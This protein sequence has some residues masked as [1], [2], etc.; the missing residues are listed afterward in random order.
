MNARAVALALTC[1]FVFSTPCAP[2][3]APVTKPV[4][5]S[6]TALDIIELEIS[7]TTLLA[8]YYK[9][10]KP[11]LL[12]DGARN[13]VAAELRAR[14]IENANL[15]LTP[16]VVDRPTGSDLID[17]LVLHS[18]ARYGSKLDGHALVNAAVEGELGILRDPY[19]VLFRP[20]AFEKFSAFLGNARF[21]GIGAI[22]SLD[23]KTGRAPIERA[24]PDS[25]AAKAGLSGGDAIVA[26]DGKPVSELSGAQ[27][28]LAALRGKIGTPVALDIAKADG[29]TVHLAL[30]RAALRDP[31]I[32]TKQF[33]N[34]SYIRL[35]RFGDRAGDEVETAARDAY[36]S[37]RAVVLDLRGNGGGYGDEATKVASV[38]IPPGP[39]F[40]TRERI[41]V[42][43]VSNTTSIALPPHGSLAVLVDGDTASAAE[44]VAGAVQDDGAGIVVGTKTFGKG[45]VQ[46]IFALPDGSAI[47]MT[48]A[49]YTTP[50]GRDIDGVGIVPDLIVAEPAGSVRGDPQTDPQLAAALS[51]L[52]PFLA[53]PSPYAP[54]SHSP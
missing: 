6:L 11:R 22:V 38:F 20:Q 29:T 19:T 37:G 36:R 13:G 18:L 5:S 17:G 27:A 9:D 48:T 1:A 35:A 25:P 33:G 8:R 31:E 51:H 23:S 4:E 42:P 54:S 44:I 14:G 3:A 53:A 47:K 2:A 21:G 16:A 45:V 12:V 28:L 34:T 30:V 26:I 52:P 43:V 46:S 24:L 32:E 39:V 7:Y 49:R 10:L 50:K 15:P 41:G 40:T